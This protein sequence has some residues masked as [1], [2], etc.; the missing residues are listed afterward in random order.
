MIRFLRFIFVVATLEL[1]LGR[2]LL[3]N[4]DPKPLPGHQ[5]QVPDVQSRAPHTNCWNCV[6]HWCRQENQLATLEFHCA[7]YN[8]DTKFP[9]K[10]YLVNCALTQ[11]TRAKYEIEETCVDG[12]D[13]VARPPPGLLGACKDGLIPDPIFPSQRNNNH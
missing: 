10:A 12:D 7:M 13:S 5:K 3:V 1:T 6:K 11:C 9:R 2:Y 8:D 4:I